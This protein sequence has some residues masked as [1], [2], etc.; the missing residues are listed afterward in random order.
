[1]VVSAVSALG[2]NV[3]VKP[4]WNPAPLITIDL[5]TTVADVVANTDGLTLTAPKPVIVIRALEVVK[6]PP[7]GFVTVAL[8]EPAVPPVSTKVPE[9]E[10]PPAATDVVVHVGTTEPAGCTN[11]TVGS[12]PVLVK[13]VP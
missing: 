11:F 6:L 9:I 5:V 3:R 10:P 13:P 8:N 2:A 4:V 1:V 7:S 12:P